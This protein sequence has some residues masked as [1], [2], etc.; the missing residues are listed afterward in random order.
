M[1]NENVSAVAGQYQT[2]PE[3]LRARLRGLPLPRLVAAAAAFE[4]AALPTTPEAATEVV[5]RG[6]AARYQHLTAELATL[7]VSTK[8]R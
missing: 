6:L 3:P 5:L 2:A 8:T 1:P 4:A 7:A